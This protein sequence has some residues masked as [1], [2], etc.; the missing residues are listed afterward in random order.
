MK[1]LFNNTY[2]GFELSEKAV[3]MYMER[4]GIKKSSEEDDMWGLANNPS[5]TDETL[6]AIVEEL[7]KEASGSC[8]QITIAEVPDGAY[9]YVDEYDGWEEIRY[10]L[11]PRPPEYSAKII[12]DFRK[13]EE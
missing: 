10:T 2:G 11:V 3:K 9:W 6:I 5:R 8:A 12:A 7:G 1:I 4:K 13:E